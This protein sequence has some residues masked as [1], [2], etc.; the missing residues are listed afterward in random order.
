MNFGLS[1]VVSAAH[2][3]PLHWRHTFS[4]YS[5]A[6]I[7]FCLFENSLIFNILMPT[8]E[9]STFRLDSPKRSVLLKG[10]YYMLNKYLDMYLYVVS[11]LSFVVH[12]CVLAYIHRYIHSFK[13]IYLPNKGSFFLNLMVSKEVKEVSVWIFHDNW[14]IPR[15]QGH[16]LQK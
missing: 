13:K 2:G 6:N 9:L 3:L 7:F 5:A 8:L 12:R 16:G 10:A 4:F 15:K 14:A 1:E 11:C